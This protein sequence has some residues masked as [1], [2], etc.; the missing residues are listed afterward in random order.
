MFT[1]IIISN[2]L[3]SSTV[4]VP[5]FSRGHRHAEY[6]VGQLGFQLRWSGSR[7]FALNAAWHWPSIKEHGSL[8][9]CRCI[10]IGALSSPG[11]QEPCVTC[12]A[13]WSKAGRFPKERV[14][15]GA[16]ALCGSVRKHTAV[17]QVCCVKCS[18][19]LDYLFWT[20]ASLTTWARGLRRCPQRDQHLKIILRV[21]AQASCEQVAG[22]VHQL[23][24]T[25][26]PQLSQG[27]YSDSGIRSWK[28]VTETQVYI[29]KR[30]CASAC[31]V[32]HPVPCL[33]VVANRMIPVSNL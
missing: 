21:R 26:T 24:L 19:T 6:G 33:E 16:S 25:R 28:S 14:P 8:Q 5:I 9:V 10:A 15:G 29:S 18:K 3:W 23:L 22:L 7:V 4:T 13:F 27:K 2:I 32:F 11:T 30:R 1:D 12:K 20:K 17:S 31:T